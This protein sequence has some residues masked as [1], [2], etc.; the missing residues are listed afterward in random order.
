MTTAWG[1]ASKQSVVYKDAS[2]NIEDRV[3]V[4]V[5]NCLRLICRQNKRVDRGE[6]SMNRGPFE[7][8]RQ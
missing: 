4:F 8:F 2:A 3:E 6:I 7:T 1:N 5:I